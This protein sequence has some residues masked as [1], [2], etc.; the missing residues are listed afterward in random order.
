MARQSWILCD[1]SR[2]AYTP[3]LRLTA[4]ELTELAPGCSVTKRTLRGGLR[5]GVDVVEID[6]GA[7]RCTVLPT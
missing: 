5:D 4:K 1:T 2:D 6:N 3:E 7:F